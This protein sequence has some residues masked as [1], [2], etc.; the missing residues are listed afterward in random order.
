MSCSNHTSELSNS[1][2]AR[3]RAIVYVD[4]NVTS[5]EYDNPDKNESKG[6]WKEFKSKLPHHKQVKP[7]EI[8]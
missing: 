8:E 6:R 4:V 1:P 7:R 2:N 3:I 5:K